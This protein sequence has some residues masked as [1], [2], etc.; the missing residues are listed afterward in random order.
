VSNN[1][2]SCKLL[3]LRRSLATNQKVACSNHAGRTTNSQFLVNCGETS[4]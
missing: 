2:Y 3:I 1:E 4:D